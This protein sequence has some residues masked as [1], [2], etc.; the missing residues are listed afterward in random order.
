MNGQYIRTHFEHHSKPCWSCRIKHVKHMKVTEGPY[1]GYE[2]EEPEY[3]NLVAWGSVIGNTCTH[4]VGHSLGLAFF[5]QDLIRPGEAF[6]N[7][8]PGD[9]YIMDSGS[10]RPFE[11]RAELGIGPAVFNDRNMDYLLDILPLP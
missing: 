10:E 3:E 9:L 6:H 4:E 8:I 7:K 1:K 11:E 5:P 2:G